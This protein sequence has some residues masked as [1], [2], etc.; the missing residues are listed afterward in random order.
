[1]APASL[2]KIDGMAFG[3]CRELVDFRLNEGVQDLGGLCLWN[4]GVAL[5]L[6]PQIQKTP[7]QLGIG[8]RDARILCLPEGL[9][10]LG[11]EWFKDSCVEKVTIPSSVRKLG[12]HAFGGCGRLCEVV[13][14]PGSCLE[15]IGDSCFIACDLRS[16]VIPRSVREIGEAA[17]YG[18]Q[19][20]SSLSFEKG[21]VLKRIGQ[22]A[23]RNTSLWPNTVRFLPTLKSSSNV[24]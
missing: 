19:Y 23:F 12:S 4:T 20:L 11:A 22:H 6:P 13:F 1:M 24:W 14:A 16:V 8:L 9:E 5:Q 7:E 2:R 15:S 10:L 17:F 21:S 3:G 18:C